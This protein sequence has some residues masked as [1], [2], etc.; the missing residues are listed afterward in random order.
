MSENW[1]YIGSSIQ[2]I[3]LYLLP[4]TGVVA[5]AVP[6]WA[7]AFRKKFPVG[8]LLLFVIT[9][10]TQI[11]MGI[12]ITFF[13]GIDMGFEYGN[14]LN[15]LSPVSLVLFFFLICLISL[16]RQYK[17][18]YIT[19]HISLSVTIY[20][21]LNLSVLFYWLLMNVLEMMYGV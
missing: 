6:S 10:F 14:T 13:S 12:F 16:Y 3:S 7:I 19:D 2:T 20:A 5:L 8:S 1:S 9:F 18:Y 4:V 17:Q 11:A 21:G 15:K